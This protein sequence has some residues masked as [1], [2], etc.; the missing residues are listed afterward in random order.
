[1]IRTLLPAEVDHCTVEVGD[2]SCCIAD[3]GAKAH[4]VVEVEG[5]GLEPSSDFVDSETSR[6]RCHD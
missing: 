1:M 5:V 3:E 6:L 4:I 2:G